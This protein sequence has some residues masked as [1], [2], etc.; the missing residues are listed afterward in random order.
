M[1]PMLTGLRLF[2]VGVQ[3]SSVAVSIS[4]MYRE[5]GVTFIVY[6]ACD[7]VPIAL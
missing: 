2:G 7:P 3:P 5:E 4:E 1:S 6:Y